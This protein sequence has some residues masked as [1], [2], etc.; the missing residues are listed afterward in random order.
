MA[1]KGTESDWKIF[2][3][4]HPIALERFCERV[5]A[6]VTRLAAQADKSGYERYKAVNRI[7]E[8]RDEEFGRAFDDL[9]RSTLLPSLLHMRRLG[10]VTDEELSRFSPDVRHMVEQVIDGAKD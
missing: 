8:K 1:V 4:L 2:K 5:L 10:L 9:R 7:L 6:E 3:K